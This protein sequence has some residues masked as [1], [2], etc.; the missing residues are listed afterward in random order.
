MEHVRAYGTKYSTGRTSLFSSG[1]FCS[2]L[3]SVR[4]YFLIRLEGMKILIMPKYRSERDRAKNR[5]ADQGL[6]IGKRLHELRSAAGWSMDDVSA[7]TGITKSSI[8]GYENDDRVPP[9]DKLAV[10]SRLYHTSVDYILGITDDP[11]PS[12]DAPDAKTF[13][14]RI[15]DISWD[16]IPLTERDL[17]LAREYF[18]LLTSAKNPPRFAADRA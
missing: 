1:G 7:K 9:A 12:T 5:R 13:L 8:S 17:K 14:S 10:F 18:D 11:T 16:G 15:T 4:R 6:M 2:T 3:C